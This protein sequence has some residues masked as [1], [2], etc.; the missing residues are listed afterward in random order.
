MYLMSY[1]SNH[2]LDEF[3]L[4]RR[5]CISMFLRPE[6]EAGELLFLLLLDVDVCG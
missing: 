5:I 6:L 1:W 4:V 2:S 3:K